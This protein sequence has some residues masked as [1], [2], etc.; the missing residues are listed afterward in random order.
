M[1]APSSGGLIIYQAYGNLNAMTG[2]KAHL[3]EDKQIPSVWVF[4]KCKDRRV[5]VYLG[6]VFFDNAETVWEELE[7]IDDRIDGS[8]LNSLWRGFDILTK[9]PDYTCVARNELVDLG[10]ML[11]LM[12]FLLGLDDIYQPIRSSILT[13]EILP[14][15]K[16]AFV[17][18]SREESYRGIPPSSVKT[19]KPQASAFMS[20]QFD[21]NNNWSNNGNNVNKG[22]YDSPLC[23]NYGLKGH[24]IDRCF[25]IIRYPS[26]YKR[27]LN[28]KPTNSFNHKSNNGDFRKANLGNNDSKT[29]GNVSFTNEQ[30]MKLMSILNGKSSSV[31]NI[32]M[33]EDDEISNLVDLHIYMLCGGWKLQD[34]L[35]LSLVDHHRKVFST[36][37]LGLDW[38]AAHNFLTCLQKLSSYAFGH[39]EVFELATCL[40]KASFSCTSGYVKVF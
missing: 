20:R 34:H 19:D 5:D 22:V 1:L 35:R 28:L 31:G 30:V 11:K 25:E 17:I 15:V 18:V 12:Q 36:N 6:H 9:L 26:G 13:R 32:Q 16:D 21:N 2:R 10:K 38:I 24:T 27:N 7:E 8:I 3:L 4:D 23:K 29:S 33:D 39:L 40:E 14:E 37:D